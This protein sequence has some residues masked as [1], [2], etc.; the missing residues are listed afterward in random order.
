MFFSTR[1]QAYQ[2]SSSVALLEGISPDGGLFLPEKITAVD[3]RTLKGASYPELAFALLRPYLDDFS[4][5]EIRSAVQEAYSPLSFPEKVFGLHLEKNEAYLELFHGKTLTFKDM[6]LSLLPHLMDVALSKHPEVGDVRILT[7]TSGDTGS[8]VLA[9]FAASKHV[10]VS[11]LYP[12][13]GIAPFQE[14]QMLSFTSSR[15][16]AYALKNANFDDCQTLVKKLLL[17]KEK[18]IT[19]SSANSINIGRLLPQIVYYYAAYIGLLKQGF[20]HEDERLDVV[21]PTGNFGDIFAA[22]LAKKMGLPLGKLVVASNANNVLTD[23]F[24]NGRYDIHREFRKTNSPSMDILVSSNLERLLYLSCLSD[25]QVAAWEKEL[26]ERGTFQVDSK[27]LAVL[28]QDFIAYSASE[29]ETAEAI[30]ECEEKEHYL[31]DPHTAVAS[32]CRKKSCLAKALIVATASPYKF[33]KTVLEALGEKVG[34][35]MAA[36]EKMMA[37][38]GDNAPAGFK[39]ALEEK[40]AKKVVSS[41]E[42]AQL[43]SPRLAF[44][45]TSPATSANLGPGFD[46]MGVA[47]SLFNS[48]RFV[49]AKEDRLVGFVGEEEI[50]DNL[51][52]KSYH[53]FFEQYGL[54]YQPV[55]L[56]QI[57]SDIPLSRGLGSSASCII[58]GLLGANAVSGDY[59]PKPDLLTLAAEIEGH[60]DN[61][62]PCLLGGLVASFRDEEG[63]YH[64]FPYAVSPKLGFLLLVCPKELSTEKARGI[65]PK[66]Y[67]L[68][69]VSFDAARLVNLPAALK[70]GNLPLLANLLEDRIHVPYRL[71]LIP[72]GE[73]VQKTAAAHHLPF[74]IS[75]AGSTLL[76][77]YSRDDPTEKEAF[78][79]DIKAFL[80]ADWRYLDLAVEKAGAHLQEVLL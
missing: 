38:C 74:T 16:R 8:A 70:E 51:I 60:P 33:P 80:S 69:D 7:A 53:R 28:K 12:E 57:R 27:T 1:N 23:F 40:T 66:N 54:P 64:P 49:P 77:L 4:D 26:K 11:V 58:A 25:K 68:A 29:K 65:L 76:V 72:E 10:K 41:R 73:R 20:I 13:G 47:L 21:V 19:Y 2:V 3:Y 30:K 9:S 43:I 78:L 71:P 34:D 32:A 14:R 31:L 6:A 15:G 61:V 37:I 50:Q 39:K 45:V 42:F 75:G 56:E 24:E 46:V 44:E 48:F 18:G 36:F 35:D 79:K 52:L 5:E 59:L 22:Y 63:H 67:A 62:A 55:K 17:K